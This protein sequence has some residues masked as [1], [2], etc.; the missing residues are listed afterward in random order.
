MRVGGIYKGLVVYDCPTA[1]DFSMMDTPRRLFRVAPRLVTTDSFR[2]RDRHRGW[3][4][5]LTV[6]EEVPHTLAWGPRGAAVPRMADQAAQAF[7]TGLAGRITAFA[8]DPS[9]AG[10]IAD[11][12]RSADLVKAARGAG[13]E[14]GT[15]VTVI[16]D[17]AGEASRTDQCMT[18]LAGFEFK[19]PSWPMAISALRLATEAVVLRHVISVDL[20]D[21][22]TRPWTATIGRLPDEANL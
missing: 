6:L 4:W 13:V 11:A 19:D 14:V 12:A 17:L 5:E 7:E 10:G 21:A 2:G 22:A 15:R 1:V 20:F 18:Y 8:L 9:V 3:C 16:A